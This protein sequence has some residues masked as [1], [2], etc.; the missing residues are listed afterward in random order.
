MEK[1]IDWEVK[2]R[3]KVRYRIYRQLIEQDSY[4]MSYSRIW[5]KIKGEFKMK[6][7]LNSLST[8]IWKDWSTERW[9][10]W[11][12]TNKV[13]HCIFIGNWLNKIAETRMK[14]I[15]G[16]ISNATKAMDARGDL[17]ATLIGFSLT[18]SSTVP[19]TALRLDNSR[20]RWPVIEPLVFTRRVSG[21]FWD[22][23][24]WGPTAR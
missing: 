1:L 4:Y 3:N 6:M 8:S 10:T 11:R 5:L 15:M 14:L 2:N 22:D 9:K 13:R 24:R 20:G 23:E 19:W 7:K 21:V 16:W 17:S 12:I 18:M